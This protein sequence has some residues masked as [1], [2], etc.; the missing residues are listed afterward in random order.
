MSSHNK[1]HDGFETKDMR[2][3]RPEANELVKIE[4]ILRRAKEIHHERGG[5]LGYDL[6]AWLEAWDELARDWG[7]DGMGPDRPEHSR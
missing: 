2:E 3:A 1:A 4:K 6:E 5:L 7:R